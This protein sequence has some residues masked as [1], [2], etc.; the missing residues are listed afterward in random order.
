MKNSQKPS[1]LNEFLGT[2]GS[3]LSYSYSEM[4]GDLEGS[5]YQSQK[6]KMSNGSYLKNV[7]SNKQQQEVIKEEEE[8]LI[9]QAS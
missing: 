2:P 1:N 7:Q 9:S 8:S 6:M 4:V 5:N 3:E